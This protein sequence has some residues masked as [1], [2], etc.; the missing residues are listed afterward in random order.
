MNTA[1]VY[2]SDNG[3]TEGGQ[4]LIPHPF[5]YIYM[6]SCAQRMFFM[7]E[8]DGS[9]SLSTAITATWGHHRGRQI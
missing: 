4:V 5:H 1:V 8:N 2:S 3:G 6:T 7:I 9:L